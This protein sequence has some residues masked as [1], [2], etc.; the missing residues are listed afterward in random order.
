MTG[1]SG[2]TPNGKYPFPTQ[3]DD[4]DVPRDIEALARALD[5][6]ASALFIGEV[7][8]FAL[9]AAP[10]RWVPCNGAALEQDAY[11]ELFDA[12]GGRFNTGGES[13]TQFRVPAI[14][15]RT[16]V[17]SGAGAGL[18]NRAIGALWGEEAHMLVTSEMPS[19][20]HTGV[21]GNDNQD[22]SHYVSGTTGAD[23]PD[24]AH[25]Q[26]GGDW[27]AITYQ[28]GSVSSPKWLGAW[29]GPTTAGATAR[30]AH[31]FSAWS[32]G[33]SARHNHY[34]TAEGGGGTHNN[35]QPS[36]AL[37]VCIYAGR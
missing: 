19:H 31:S 3:D 26:Q 25:Q 4:V 5:P 36:I 16:I 14:A 17:G 12:L 33:A 18:T 24:H 11:P 37:L 35:A 30:H 15:G 32:G 10:A 9:V 34:I 27:P 8:S 1:P 13:A 2:S 7:R 20:S 21:T 22:H 28:G 23:S 6:N 29:A